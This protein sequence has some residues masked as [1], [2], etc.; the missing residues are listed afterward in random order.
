MVFPLF[1]GNKKGAYAP[2][3]RIKNELL[4]D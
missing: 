3:C 2:R 4:K 1:E